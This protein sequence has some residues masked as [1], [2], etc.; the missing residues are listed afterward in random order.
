MALDL[1]NHL[2]NSKLSRKEKVLTLLAASEADEGV[3]VSSLTNLAVANG[4]PQAK[5]WNFSQ[6]LKDLGSK[7]VRL[8]GGWVITLEGKAALDEL[9]ILSAAPSKAIQPTL[10]KYASSL[11]NPDI[12]EF[13]EEA[14][15]AVEFKLYRSAVVLSWVGATRV[16]YEEVI[17]NHLAPFNAEAVKRLPKWKA[18]KTAEDLTRMKE[19]DFLQ[20]I[21]SI[22]IVGKNT[23]DELEGCLKLRNTCGHPNSHKIGEHKVTA[24]IETLI[25]NVFAKF[26]I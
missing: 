5:K 2:A 12:Q 11:T 9:G 17:K 15:S 1:K 22:G 24:H 23:K 21:A 10:R 8:P 25:L 4:L 3:P 6:I 18:A 26:I 20:V 19:Y 16:L 13:V 14:I 7:A